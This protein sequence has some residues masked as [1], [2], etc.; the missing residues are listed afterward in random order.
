MGSFTVFKPQ[1]CVTQLAVISQFFQNLHV[2][3]AYATAITLT[4]ASLLTEGVWF[5]FHS[6]KKMPSL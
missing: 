1:H 3:S 6:L 2:L 4:N 5:S